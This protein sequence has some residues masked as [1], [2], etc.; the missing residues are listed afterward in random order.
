MTLINLKAAILL[1]IASICVVHPVHPGSTPV[2]EALQEQIVI[3]L[4]DASMSEAL[5]TIA[6]AGHIQIAGPAD[7]PSGITMSLT[8]QP[9]SKVLDILAKVSH[10]TWTLSEDG[11]VVFTKSQDVSEIP[12]AQST[13]VLTPEQKMAALLSSLNATQLYKISRGLSLAYV[14]LSPYQKNLLK[15]I[16]SPPMVGVSDFGETI[17]VLPKPADAHICFFT[18]PYLLIPNPENK[19][20]I[21]LRLDSRPYISLRREESK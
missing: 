15:S 1:L 8:N 9:I 17:R 7:P 14:E 2:S 11:I 3:R 12:V 21:L 4:A 6:K 16:L 20:P 5:L 13:D 10:T 19:K 18:L